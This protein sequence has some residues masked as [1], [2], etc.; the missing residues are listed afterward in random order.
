[1]K[2]STTQQC[3]ASAQNSTVVATTAVVAA[4]T[5]RKMCRTCVEGCANTFLFNECSC[6]KQHLQMAS[7]QRGQSV[8]GSG[9]FCHF[10]LD[11]I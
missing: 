2:F 8:V 3:L 11:F 4:N 1:M 6:V 5:C 7:G 10:W 9:Q